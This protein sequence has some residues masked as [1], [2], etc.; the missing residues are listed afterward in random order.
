MIKNTLIRITRSGWF[1]VIWTI[2]MLSLLFIPGTGLPKVAKWWKFPGY[3]KVIHFFLFASLV[4]I[5]MFHFHYILLIQQTRFKRILLIMSVI[6]IGV[7][8]G[9][10][11]IQ[12]YFIPHRSFDVAD[13][14]ADVVGV[15]VAAIGIY[16]YVYKTDRQEKA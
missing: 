15:L 16:Y 12:K 11:F 5:W 7:G 10:E 1:P 8:V 9:T 3:D 14:Y 13:I 2:I 4:T 6:F